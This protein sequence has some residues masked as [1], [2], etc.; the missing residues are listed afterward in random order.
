MTL[1]EI[2]PWVGLYLLISWMYNYSKRKNKE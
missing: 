2:L 1:G